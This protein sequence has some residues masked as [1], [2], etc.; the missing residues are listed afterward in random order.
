MSLTETLEKMYLRKS[1]KRKINKTH[2]HNHKSFVSH[3]DITAV[4]ILCNLNK[5]KKVIHTHTHNLGMSYQPRT[6]MAN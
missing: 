1:H 6:T 3:A 5:K 2:K 4:A